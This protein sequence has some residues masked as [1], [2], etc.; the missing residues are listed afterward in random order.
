MMLTSHKET[1]A[2]SL[3]NHG[4]TTIVLTCKQEIEEVLHEFATSPDHVWCNGKGKL[5][6]HKFLKSELQ[7]QDKFFNSNPS[8]VNSLNQEWSDFCDDCVLLYVL[9]AYLF[10]K[11]F[12]LIHPD[13]Y[14]ANIAKVTINATSGAVPDLIAGIPIKQ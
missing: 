14:M 7:Q 13:S 12:E 10:N 9:D 6:L 5:Y 1:C 11:P 8:L 2:I 4:I 3:G